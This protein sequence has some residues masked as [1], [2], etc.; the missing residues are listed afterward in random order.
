MENYSPIV[1]NQKFEELAHEGRGHGYG[2]V[3]QTDNQKKPIRFNVNRLLNPD[4]KY[5]FRY[6]SKCKAGYP[7][8][9][10]TYPT[11]VE[12]LRNYMS[13]NTTLIEF[14]QVGNDGR[15]YWLSC[16][17][18]KAGKFVNIDLAI[19]E[20]LDVGIMHHA[21]PKMVDWNLWKRMNT[22]THACKPYVYNTKND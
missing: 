17:N 21:F 15:E 1:K 14:K 19:L 9:G 13:K 7:I 3:F 11:T 10:Q 8:I 16:L 2:T 20:R 6:I 18:M 12:G 22:K 4:E 5:E